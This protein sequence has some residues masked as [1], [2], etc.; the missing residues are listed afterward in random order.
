M[1]RGNRERGVARAGWQMRGGFAAQRRQQAAGFDAVEAAVERERFAGRDALHDIEEFVGARIAAVVIDEVAVRTLVGA[2]AARDDVP[3]DAP[4]ADPL[5]ARGHLRRIDRV[6][7]MRLQR[8]QEP[9]PARLARQRGRHDPRFLR[10]TK[11]RNQRAVEA[12]ISA[13]RA[14]CDR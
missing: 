11:D 2:A 9:Q 12:A 6:H 7:E 8:D 10:K 4:T 13:A 1:L 5:Q 3:L 14:T